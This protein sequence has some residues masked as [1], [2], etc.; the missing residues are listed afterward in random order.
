VSP[1][2]DLN[3]VTAHVKPREQSTAINID[4]DTTVSI[5][6]AVDAAPEF[7]LEKDEARKIAG[8]VVRAVRA[9]RNLASEVGVRREEMER[10]TTAFEHED[11]TT[12]E[13]WS[14]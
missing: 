13:S 10:M 11:A 3:P 1:A 8:E 2:Y 12:A 7:F 6:L 4:G 9:L 5:E 14:N